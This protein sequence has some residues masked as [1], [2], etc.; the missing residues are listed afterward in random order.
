[1][2]HTALREQHAEG[3]PLWELVNIQSFKVSAPPLSDSFN[4]FSISQNRMFDKNFCI[5]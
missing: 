4:S 3:E 5:I 1:M 2:N